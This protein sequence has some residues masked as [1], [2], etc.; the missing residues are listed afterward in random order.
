MSDNKKYSKSE[1]RMLNEVVEINYKMFIDHKN[2]QPDLFDSKL[3]Y[4]GNFVIIKVD[5]LEQRQKL[6]E[7]VEKEIYPDY[8]ERKTKT[9]IA[10]DF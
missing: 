10:G 3:A 8:N 7:F 9:N 1:I 6:A 5:S 4:M 2:K